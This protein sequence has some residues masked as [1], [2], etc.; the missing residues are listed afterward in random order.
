[1]NLAFVQTDNTGSQD[2]DVL[3]ALKPGH[4]PTE[5]YMERIRRELPD[6][7]PGSSMYFQPADIVSQVLNFGLTAP[8]DVQIDGPDVNKSYEVARTLLQKIRAIPG[9]TDVRIPQVLA[10]PALRLNVDR[11]R[12]AQIGITE[13]DVANNLLVSLSSSSLVAPSFWINP[14]NNV[15]YFVAVQTPIRQVDSVPALLGT[16]LGRGT[17]LTSSSVPASSSPASAGP[18]SASAPG[19]VSNGGSTYLGAVAR[20]TPA[21]GLSMINHV[22]VQRVVDVQASA[23]GRDLGG[24]TRDIEKAISSLGQLPKA[25]RITVR[26]QSES[27]FAAFGRLGLGLILAIALVYLLLVIL[28]QSFL[29]PF[30]ILVAV[31]GA[32]VGI[33]WMLAA[34]GTTLNVESFMGAIM[35][36]G[37]AT[38]NSILLV[39]A[40]NDARVHGKGVL[41]AAVEAGKT[42]LR[43][44]LMTAL[45]MMLGMVPM[46]LALGE[47]GEQNAPLGRAVIGGLIVATFV[48]LFVVPA[49]YTLLRTAPPSAHQLD[50]QFALESHGASEA[51]HA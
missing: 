19:D 18:S 27:M 22:S 34:T 29:D 50:E 30:I 1:Y 21:T 12:A 14:K 36:V 43:P 2:A 17:T 9:A 26:G 11:A 13:R 4:A 33:L 42:R 25:T 40:A 7:F 16:P 10:Y 20:L 45:A 35:A 32:L 51:S 39:N 28:F 47:G 31:P 44:V 15:N 23:S 49:V 6:E 24:V 46:A 5:R 41:E 8:I 37:I 38:S 48:T 3:V